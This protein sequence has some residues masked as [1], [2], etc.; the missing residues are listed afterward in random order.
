MNL[1]TVLSALATKVSTSAVKV[2][3]RMPSVLQTPAGFV[4]EI[5]VTPDA[6][7]EGNVDLI[8][9]ITYLFS[10]ADLDK[11]WELL[12]D[13]SSSATTN[14]LWAKLQ[15]D[16]DLSISGVSTKLERL[17]GPTLQTYADVDYWAVTATVSVYGT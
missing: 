2:T 1:D 13:V 14:S 6:T 7:F 16:P 17:L 9:E 10:M 15:A 4:S 12:N 11:S 5:A 8:V 3:K